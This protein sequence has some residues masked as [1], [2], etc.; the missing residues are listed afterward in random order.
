[1]KR[2]ALAMLCVT[3]LCAMAHVAN[4]AS[5]LVNVGGAQLAFSPQ[6][7]TINPNDTVIF[8]NKGGQHN[9]VADD[10]SFRCAR[11]CD[12]DG[13]GGNGNA[14]NA[15]WTSSV[16]FTKPGTVGYFCEIHGAPGM[17]MYGTII[18]QGQTQQSAPIAVPSGTTLLYGL[19]VLVIVLAAGVATRR[20]RD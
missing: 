16:T 15:N 20:R 3:M 17:G 10:G 18:V 19:L 13:M 9:A 8:V 2:F 12:G 6:T 14:S 7:V 1:M 4:A 5:V 11:G